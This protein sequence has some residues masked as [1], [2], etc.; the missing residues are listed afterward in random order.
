MPNFNPIEHE[1]NGHKCLVFNMKDI[2]QDQAAEQAFQAKLDSFL[3]IYQHKQ[4]PTINENELLCFMQEYIAQNPGSEMAIRVMI[5]KHLLRKVKEKGFYTDVLY[6]ASKL[7]YQFLLDYPELATAYVSEFRDVDSESQHSFSL[8]YSAVYSGH[9]LPIVCMLKNGAKLS[10]PCKLVLETNPPRASATSGLYLDI[11]Y[12]AEKYTIAV[13]SAVLATTKTIAANYLSGKMSDYN[14]C[15]DQISML[16]LICSD[17]S[18]FTALQAMVSRMD[19]LL[20]QVKQGGYESSWPNYTLED[21]AYMDIVQTISRFAHQ[22]KKLD[23]A[24]ESPEEIRASLYA[25]PTP[26]AGD[27][28]ILTADGTT[29]P[30]PLYI[31]SG[32]DRTMLG[33]IIEETSR[34]NKTLSNSRQAFFPAF[35][36][37][38]RELTDP[39][40][41]SVDPD[42]KN[43]EQTGLVQGKSA[44]VRMY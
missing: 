34:Q 33:R 20:E 9:L 27:L 23:K 43:P 31:M 32:S 17:A 39:L 3:V 16:M 14:E 44:S 4:Y 24:I 7:I 19:L 10:T 36:S 40:D 8:L 18:D 2:F 11:K 15:N 21:H 38:F 42:E 37:S 22:A 35:S 5:M 28:S 1:A 29:Q 12:L 6:T 25:T 41:K 26:Y 13:D 30:T